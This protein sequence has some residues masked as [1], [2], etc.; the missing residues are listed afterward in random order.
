MHPNTQTDTEQSTLNKTMSAWASSGVKS[1]SDQHKTPLRLAVEMLM[2]LQYLRM[3]AILRPM[4]Y[5]DI[6][7]RI[8]HP[9]EQIAYE[10]LYRYDDILTV[11]SSHTVQR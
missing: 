4:M 9:S 10:V 6:H 7:F 1:A 11:Y 3:K 2:I 5:V 8:L